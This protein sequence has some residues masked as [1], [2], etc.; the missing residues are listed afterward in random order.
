MVVTATAG[1]LPSE[2]GALPYNQQLIRFKRT[3]LSEALEKAGG[4]VKH[5]A[6]A[7]EISRGRLYR[8]LKTVGLASSVDEVE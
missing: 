6:A 8:E 7:L 3:V 5:A 2:E 4:V 1:G